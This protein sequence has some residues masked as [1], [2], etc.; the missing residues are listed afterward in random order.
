MGRVISL[1]GFIKDNY[2]LFAVAALTAITTFVWQMNARG[3]RM[4]EKI[5]RH[6]ERIT[7]AE[8]KIEDNEHRI[9]K[10]ETEIPYLSVKKKRDKI[11]QEDM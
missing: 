11:S 4:E 7:K 9:T 8:V 2:E 1:K 10:I 5:D 6:E 3:A